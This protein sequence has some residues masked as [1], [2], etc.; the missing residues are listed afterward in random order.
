[1][2]LSF[3]DLAAELRTKV[4]RY[5]LQNEKALCPDST[6]LIS[7]NKD[8]YADVY[9]HFEGA[10]NV[11]RANKQIHHE[12]S[13]VLYGDNTFYFNDELFHGTCLDCMVQSIMCFHGSDISVMHDWLLT[14]G[15]HNRR[16]LRYIEIVVS[17]PAF[18]QCE[19]E[20]HYLYRPLG[21]A[22]KKSPPKGKHLY[23]AL[24]LLAQ[25]GCL[26]SL[27]IGFE[28]PE[29]YDLADY[30]FSNGLKGQLVQQLI[31]LG[32]VEEFDVSPLP[33]TTLGLTTLSDL[34]G[35]LLHGDVRGT[36]LTAKED[37]VVE[38]T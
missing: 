28:G 34:N 27:W 33:R 14:I 36:S 35:I 21:P 2:K 18:L 37:E 22:R 5:L 3:L 4:Y 10:T 6:G 16:H 24:G 20:F 7:N 32:R 31:K 13:A 15:S 38:T 11:L 29:Q 26:Q 19:G 1:M 17:E 23:D 8:L 12:A 30:L 9:M 25:D